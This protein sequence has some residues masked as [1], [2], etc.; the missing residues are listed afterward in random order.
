[1]TVFADQ[2]VLPSVTVAA[3]SSVLLTSLGAAVSSLGSVALYAGSM[4]YDW[5][6][7][8]VVIGLFLCGVVGL[9]SGVSAR[10][11]SMRSGVPQTGTERLLTGLSIVAGS[12]SVGVFL[13]VLMVMGLFVV[14]ASR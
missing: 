9:Y 8:L 12:I 4:R 11:S 10:A 6:S 14:L 2:N 3:P 5:S 7:A 1:M 13:M